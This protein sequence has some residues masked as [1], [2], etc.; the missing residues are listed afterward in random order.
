MEERIA[1]RFRITGADLTNL[2]TE[3]L[4]QPGDYGCID[5]VGIDTFLNVYAVKEDIHANKDIKW[6]LCNFTLAQK[7]QR[8]PDGSLYTYETLLREE[9][10]LKI[11]IVS[12]TQSAYIPTF[13]TKRWV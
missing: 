11:W 13:S 1:S 6:D 5:H 8:D 9:H 4:K 12:G 10:N 2:Y 7:Y 3:C